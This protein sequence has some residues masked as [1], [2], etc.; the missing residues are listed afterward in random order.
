MC[1]LQELTD[2]LERDHG[3]FN[4]IVSKAI[5]AQKATEAAKKARELVRRKS[6]LVKSTLPGKLADCS[7]TDMSKSEIF[8]VE[9]DSAGQGYLSSSFPKGT[10]CPLYHSLT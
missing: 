1:M 2:I 8:I 4:A 5:Q 9:G 6:V 10:P 3:A 7:S